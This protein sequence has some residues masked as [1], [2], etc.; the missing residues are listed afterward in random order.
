LALSFAY[1]AQTPRTET[2]I[3]HTQF[4]FYKRTNR[5]TRLRVYCQ[6]EGPLSIKSMR[7]IAQ[8]CARLQERFTGGTGEPAFQSSEVEDQG[9]GKQVSVHLSVWLEKY[10]SRGDYRKSSE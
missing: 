10:F 5:A 4:G 2:D 9:D 3:E 6:E 1:P 8:A 7:I